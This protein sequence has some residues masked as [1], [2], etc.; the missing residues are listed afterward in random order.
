MD[1]GV[2]GSGRVSGR[3][4]IGLNFTSIET[5][6][7]TERIQT[8]MVDGTLRAP[9]TKKRDVVTIVGLKDRAFVERLVRP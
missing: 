6:N 1:S 4:I 8:T 2:E 9:G 3:A 5:V 7:G